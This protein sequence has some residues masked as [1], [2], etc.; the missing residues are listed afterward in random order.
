MQQKKSLGQHFL[1]DKNIS[2]KIVRSAGVN[3]SDI[4]WEIGPGEG[5]LTEELLKKCK[6]L[7][8]FEIDLRWANFISKKFSSPK[9]KVVNQ[10][11]LKV[12]F[13]YYYENSPVKLVSNI[14]YQI[15]SPLLIKLADN[16]KLFSSITLMVQDEVAER[17]VGIPGTKSYGRLSIKIQYYFQ[18]EKLFRVPP[19][20]FRPKPRITSAVIQLTPRSNPPEIPDKTLFWSLIDYTFQHRRKMLR[21]SLRD[22]LEPKTYQHLIHTTDFDFTCR[23]E[24]LAIENFIFLTKQIKKMHNAC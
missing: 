10:D 20:V 6:K 7:I 12:N 15:T 4:V 2:A 14:P 23:P 17:V 19:H 22:F 21:N 3:S 11:I 1:I 24:E 13:S 18:A 8:V 16:N 5:I 9:L